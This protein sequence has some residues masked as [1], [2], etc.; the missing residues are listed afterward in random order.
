M[1][2]DISVLN[3]N[4]NNEPEQI[5][6][7]TLRLYSMTGADF[8]GYVSIIPEGGINEDTTT[9][10]NSPYAT[11]ELGTRIGQFRSIWP[12]QFYEMDITH[13]FRGGVI[14]K[15]FLIRISSDH[16]NGVMWRS[17]DGASDNGPRLVVKFAYEPDTNKALAKLFGS[18]PPTPL[19]TMK[20][21]IPEWSNPQTP[22][23]PLRTYFNY[24]PRSSYGPERWNRV[25]SD[26]YHDK[27]KKLKTDV[28]RNKC[29]DGRRQSP[30]DLCRTNDKC[31]EYHE[32]R[33]RV[34]YICIVL[35]LSCINDGL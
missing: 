7:A 18:D 22:S 13:A 1:K 24:N 12:S 21:T 3:G 34:S 6:S 25:T 14:P 10:D 5:L 32:T 33:P 16:Q 35:L 28:W 23:N 17:T 15:T 19:P 27:F 9:W 31:L 2:F 8:G 20:P 29:K 30:R 26:G 11:Q 4:T